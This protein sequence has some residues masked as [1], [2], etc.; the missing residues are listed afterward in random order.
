MADFA[1]QTV[2][3]NPKSVALA[4]AGYEILQMTVIT[5][6]ARKPD[7]RK[8]PQAT[9]QSVGWA[10]REK[11]ATVPQNHGGAQLMQRWW[12]PGAQYRST[13][14][15]AAPKSGAVPAKWAAGTLRISWKADHGAQ[16]HERLV[17]VSGV[18]VG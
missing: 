5:M 3:A 18:A 14:N 9:K 1:Q 10:L 15:R 6:G 8:L 13:V 16:V 4:Y 17:V 7:V 11:D 12:S 2:G